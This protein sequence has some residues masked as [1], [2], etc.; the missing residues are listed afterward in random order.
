MFGQISPTKSIQAK[1]PCLVLAEIQD[2]VLNTPNWL[3]D[4]RLGCDRKAPLGF[5]SELPFRSYVQ[6]SVSNTRGNTGIYN[7]IPNA[8]FPD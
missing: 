8:H 4:T 7:K 2:F 5:K 3:Y 1:P 6:R